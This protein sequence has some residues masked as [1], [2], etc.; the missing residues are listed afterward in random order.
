M[1]L[2]IIGAT[3]FV[4]SEL[5]KEVF[6]NFNQI[7]EICCFYHSNNRCCKIQK[8]NRGNKNIFQR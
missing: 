7:D 4:G 8:N 3:G 1:K 2:T 6:K 5:V